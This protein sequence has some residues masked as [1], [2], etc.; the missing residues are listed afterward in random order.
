[1]DNDEEA[2]SYIISIK[3]KYDIVD[4]SITSLDTSVSNRPN[5]MTI[6]E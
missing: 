4:A 5:E 2:Q 6:L 3:D 1:M